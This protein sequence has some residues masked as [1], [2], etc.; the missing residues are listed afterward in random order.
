M[1]SLSLSLCSKL[2]YPRMFVHLRQN[3]FLWP[4]NL[5]VESQR[6]LLRQRPLSLMHLIPQVNPTIACFR[7]RTTRNHCVMVRFISQMNDLSS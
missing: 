2:T 1:I 6:L 5:K 4:G 3:V 7:L